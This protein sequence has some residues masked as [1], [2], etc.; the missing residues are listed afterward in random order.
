MKLNRKPKQGIAGKWGEP[1]YR[2]MAESAFADV[3]GNPGPGALVLISSDQ[4]FQ[5]SPPTSHMPAQAQPCRV[6]V[7]T[8][9][10]SLLGQW[11]AGRAQGHLSGQEPLCCEPLGA[12][13][14]FVVHLK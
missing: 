8:G 13:A 10:A 12:R 4:T 11:P 3:L 2:M 9:R 5:T 7:V 1:W 14:G 6:Q